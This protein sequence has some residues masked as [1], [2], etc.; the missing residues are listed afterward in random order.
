MSESSA[1]YSSCS[2]FVRRELPL[3]LITTYIFKFSIQKL[4]R[5]SARIL[6]YKLNDLYVTGYNWCVS[7]ACKIR[8]GVF[9]KLFI[10][11][12]F[13]WIHFLTRRS[14]Q[15]L[16]R[17][18]SWLYYL[19]NKRITPRLDV[20]TLL[21]YSCDQSAD[22]TYPVT[23]QSKY[24]ADR[25]HYLLLADRSVENVIL[26]HVRFLLQKWGISGKIIHRHSLW[27]RFFFQFFFFLYFCSLHIAHY[28]FCC[29][30]GSWNI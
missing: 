27:C 28:S 4:R 1:S 18:Y 24:I 3:K 13:V 11:R 7:Q 20:L 10:F 16:S 14:S 19:G 8:W 2:S 29:F 9:L 17:V 6:L 5:L 12:N 26:S 22:Y 30:N 25:R 15:E 23:Q 21:M